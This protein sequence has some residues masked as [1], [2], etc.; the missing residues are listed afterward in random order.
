MICVM[1]SWMSF[2][3]YVLL[4]QKLCLAHYRCLINVYSWIKHILRWAC[5]CV[6]TY[7]SLCTYVCKSEVGIAHL[8]LLLSIFFFLDLGSCTKQDLSQGSQWSAYLCSYAEITDVCNYIQCSAGYWDLNSCPPAFT[9]G[10]L[11]RYLPSPLLGLLMCD[12][13]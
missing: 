9:K 1:T 12:N 7:V 5:V 4:R 6:C 13:M 2:F 10:T 3:F 11:L 8:S